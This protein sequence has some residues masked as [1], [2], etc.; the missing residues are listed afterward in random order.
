M[1]VIKWNTLGE[2]GGVVR[3]FWGTFSLYSNCLLGPDSE[4]GKDT[5]D[6]DLQGGD[7]D[8]NIG[9]IAEDLKPPAKIAEAVGSSLA[10]EKGKWCQIWWQPCTLV[11][12]FGEVPFALTRA[13]F[14][15]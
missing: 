6:T 7:D 14:I 5:D 3:L 12:T 11:K 2:I 15:L 4:E 13:T 10:G 9:D 1:N 8:P